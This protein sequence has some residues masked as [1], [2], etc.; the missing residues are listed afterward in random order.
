VGDRLLDR[1]RI[2]AVF[3]GGMG[4]LW[5]CTDAHTG[6]R[7]AIKGI[8]PEDLDR[9]GFAQSFRR[10]AMTWIALDQHPNLVQALWLIDDN[11]LGPVLVL[12][13]VD[14]GDLAS[15]LENGPLPLERGLDLAMQCAAGLQY[16][17]TRRTDFGVGV[18]HRDL[19][20]S[21]LLVTADGVLK[22]ADFGLARV[23]RTST[24]AGGTPAY[25]APE[26]L[27]EGARVDGRADVYA[28]GLVLYEILT[29]ANPLA[30]PDLPT[31]IQRTLHETPPPLE[32]V[33]SELAALVARCVAKDPT[34]RPRD[35]GEVL[36]HLAR[37]ARTLEYPWHVDLDSIAEPTE[38]GGL[39]IGVPVL[40]PRRQRAGE[41]F[42]VEV[43][44]RGD[45]GPGPVDVEWQ[46]REPE[47]LQL[48]TPEGGLRVR[49][50]AGGSVQLTAQV[51]FVA[52]DEGSYEIA[53]SRVVARGPAGKTT[54]PVRP[55]TAEVAFAFVLPWRGREREEALLQRVIRTRTGALVVYG[56][57]GTGKT[58]LLR[59]A[60]RIAAE[61]DVRVVGSRAHRTGLRPMRVLNE[62]AREI[63]NLA[64][65]GRHGVRAAVHELVGDDAPTA[66]YFAQVLTGGAA[67]E[68]EA[69]PAHYWFTLLRAACEREP[70][71][72]LLDDLHHADEA[73][74][75]IVL[76]LAARV[77]AERLP[78]VIIATFGTGL[79]PARARPRLD[80][81]RDGCRE[82]GIP[83]LTLEPLGA[84]DI[85]SLVEAVFP[86]HGFAEEAPWLVEAILASTGGNP[87]H[88]AEILRMLRLGRDGA[89]ERREGE[90]RLDP[91]LSPERVRELVP[92]ALEAAVLGRLGQLSA[93]ANEVL[94][95]A[96]LIG[97]EFDAAVLR[98]ATGDAAATD[99]ALAELEREEV[100]A[101]VAPELDR[102]R[103]W[104][105]TVPTVVERRL[106]PDRRQRL[107]RA[108][109]NGMLETYRGEERVRHSLSIAQLLR[110][111]GDGLASLPFT[112]EGC[113]RL[114]TLHLPERA[115]R[116]LANAKPLFDDPAVSAENRAFFEYLYGLACEATGDY[117]EGLRSLTAFVESSI[118][119]PHSPRSVPR[120]HVRLGRIHQAR[121]QYDEAT[122][123]FN[124]ARELYQEIGDLRRLAFVHL[125]LAGLALE[126][127]A[128]ADA[129]RDLDAAQRLANETGNEGAAILA[130]IQRGN[131]ALRWG[132][133]AEARRVFLEGERRARALDDRRH[134]AD[135]LEG[136][137]RVALAAGYLRQ[138]AAWIGETSELRAAMGDRPG[139]ARA[140]LHLG[141][142]LRVRGR[143]DRALHQYRRAQRVFDEIGHPA[144]V[145][146]ARYRAGCVLRARGKTAAAVRELA[147][148]SET[149]QR[150]R[151]PDRPQVLAE[152]GRALANAGSERTARIALAR[153]DRAMPAGAPRRAQRVRSRTLR[154]ALALARDDLDRAQAWARRAARAGSRTTGHGAR[155][156]AQLCLAETSLR[157]GDEAAA[158]P[159]AE[160]AL[161]FARAHGDPLAEAVAR[162]VLAELAARDDRR[163]EAAGHA[164]LAARAYTGRADVGDAPARLLQAL[165]RGL[166]EVDPHRAAQYGR[167]ARRCY[168]LLEAQ[169]FR[170]PELA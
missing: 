127:G 62:L 59:E 14:G 140:M 148:A 5:A 67:F 100:V 74:I 63:L 64:S 117:D 152:L 48:L 21:N 55:F 92:D 81:M 160:T 93:A 80:A 11:D 111:A 28:F 143:V 60:A 9:P 166:A 41:P 10:E 136:A 126:R 141:D 23:L 125:S 167:A 96:G 132:R 118:E 85:E 142:V 30:S 164:H 150:L 156:T 99:A 36:A 114:L 75:R 130:L 44:I 124:V 1:F 159:A 34:A 71:V 19:K 20:P 161:A 106:D 109:A 77:R 26:Q 86:G 113:E 149:L 101:V 133:L 115:R 42:L 56:D 131:L 123:S 157:A 169:G 154:A 49:V 88:V 18:V 119:L 2:D 66:R 162:Q 82:L 139:L 104:S 58:R 65:H 91:G 94:D 45:V 7:Y 39:V 12:E 122:F 144:G 4:I 135:A 76:D 27:V 163:R 112:L 137:G 83:Q 43:K 121:G 70:I 108:V 170:V 107:H 6:R 103:F 25:M 153:A 146:R 38:P 134:R 95:L 69:P 31:Q 13:F 145:A 138:A 158:R 120:A 116:L 105:A 155:I 22:I 51:S 84:A 110:G 98:A 68:H 73:A 90:W 61:E 128:P 79:D 53:E 8:K 168:A 47:G 102:Y 16:A 3:T 29:G 54:Y 129:S 151:H 37:V 24:E 78:V 89:I 17:H 35:I 15:R 32:E 87:F 147:A 97:E 46:V 33:P 165:A 52:E 72:V 50:E 57:V 40:R